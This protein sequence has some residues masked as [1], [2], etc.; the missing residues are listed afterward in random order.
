MSTERYVTGKDGR[1]GRGVAG[2]PA[3]GAGSHAVGALPGRS[4]AQQ[5]SGPTVYVG[6]DDETL[7]AVD[8]ATCFRT[9]GSRLSPS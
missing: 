5:A 4:S 7:Y 1:R 3:T 8:A 2:D 6:D 9:R